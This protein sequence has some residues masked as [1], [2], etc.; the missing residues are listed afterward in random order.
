MMP[1]NKTKPTEQAPEEFIRDL[2]GG[3]KADALALMRL[4]AEVTGEAPVMWGGSLV[5]FGKYRYRY[6]SGHT[7][8]SARVGFSP[9]KQALTLYLGYSLEA[10]EKELEAL[11]KHSRGKGCLYIKR[12]SDID[13]KVLRLLVKKAYEEATDFDAREAVG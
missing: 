3:K 9:R 10:L 8:E 4:M 1:E 13:E 7:G 12:L 2:P 11:G 5:G 6:A